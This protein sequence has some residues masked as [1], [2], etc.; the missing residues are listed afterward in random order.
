MKHR[1][2]PWIR[3]VVKNTLRRD[4]KVSVLVERENIRRILS[5]GAA[6]C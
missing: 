5:A 2:I 6:P 3:I 4:P 1:A